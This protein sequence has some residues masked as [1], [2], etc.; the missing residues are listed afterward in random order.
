VSVAAA[1]ITSTLCKASPFLWPYA[2]TRMSSYVLAGVSSQGAG[3]LA[4]TMPVQRSGKQRLDVYLEPELYEWIHRQ[5]S[6]Q[7]RTMSGWMRFV[8]IQLREGLTVAGEGGTVTGA[9]P[10]TEEP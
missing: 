9:A 6:R 2:R 5:A 3:T 1:W 10:P 7:H 8:I 4:G